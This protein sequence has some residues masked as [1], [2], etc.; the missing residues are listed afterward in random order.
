MTTPASTKEDTPQDV[1]IHAFSSPGQAPDVRLNAL[2]I[3]EF[4][5]HSFLLKHHSAFFRKFLDSP[6]KQQGDNPRNAEELTAVK[7]RV[8]K[9]T[10]FRYEWVTQFDEVGRGWH[11]VAAS[12]M[13]V[14]LT[15][16]HNL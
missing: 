8:G 2:G 16:I 14:S 1:M 9:V 11:L 12:N 4:H 5:V 10:K 7:M 3:N 15:T 6:D 13:Q